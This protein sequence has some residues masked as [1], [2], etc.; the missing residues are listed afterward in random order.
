M[1]Q[2]AGQ[3]PRWRCTAT[4]L[5]FPAIPFNAPTEPALIPASRTPTTSSQT[6]TARRCRALAV[7]ALLAPVY[8]G[9]LFAQTRPQPVRDNVFFAAMINGLRARF[10]QQMATN[11]T[12]AVVQ[13]E[14]GIVTTSTA[15]SVLSA[16]VLVRVLREVHACD[17]PIQVWHLAE[18]S[19]EDCQ[20]LEAFPDVACRNLAPFVADASPGEVEGYAIKALALVHCPFRH[21]IFLDNDNVP[22][23]NP[24]ILLS[25]PEYR[26]AGALFW[27]D[28]WVGRLPAAQRSSDAVPT[29]GWQALAFICGVRDLRQLLASNTGE[30][31]R[32]QQGFFSWFESGQ[33]VI[34]RARHARALCALRFL[35][36]H[37][38][39]TYRLVQGDKDTFLFAW[40]GTRSSFAL[41]SSRAIP[42]GAVVRASATGR[43]AFCG[44]TMGQTV[45]P[46]MGGQALAF[47]HRNY[48]SKWHY[49][50]H[51]S[52][53]WRVAATLEA[54]GDDD[55]VRLDAAV[56]H[57]YCQ[58]SAIRVRRARLRSL[59]D[60][61]VELE[62]RCVAFVGEFPSMLPQTFYFGRL[63]DVFLRWWHGDGVL[64]AAAID[65]LVLP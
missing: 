56:P 2:S 44:H 21:A 48:H 39:I 26:R 18:L 10:A 8:A 58:P 52:M 38:K 55:S 35:N 34:D 62:R 33:L 29:Q 43:L 16:Y 37:G 25:T 7:L 54:R 4:S 20:L 11:V 57:A 41:A 42:V 13:G 53:T 22:A 49:G 64:E 59:P 6:A 27:P 40:L 63:A 36:M 31:A 12:T 32:A 51:R 24:A 46:S 14:S 17:L 23:L 60:S 65:G 3:P 50:R 30:G 28:L 1:L 47:L 45:P 15:A 9:M 19:R 61:I 5:E